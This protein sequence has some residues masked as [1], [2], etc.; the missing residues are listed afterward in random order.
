VNQREFVARCDDDGAAFREVL[1]LRQPVRRPADGV[2]FDERVGG[3]GR[4][5]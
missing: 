1:A 3:D 4:G 2:P 5:N